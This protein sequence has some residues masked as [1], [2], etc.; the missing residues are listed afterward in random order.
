LDKSLAW[1]LAQELPRGAEGCFAR[2]VAPGIPRE[3]ARL[4]WCHGDAGVAAALLVAA[5]AIQEPALERV[6]LRIALRAAARSEA[7]A[8]VVD[9]GLCHGAAGVAH[10]FH[11]IYLATGEERI[12][13]AARAWFKRALAMRN[14]GRGFGGFL[15]YGP[16]GEG[17]LGRCGQPG[18]LSGSAGVT[19]ALLAATTGDDPV[20]D[21][22]LLLS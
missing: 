11:R 10:I 2:A 1:L 3:P 13:T 21:R 22:A 15:T 6:S 4:A 16:V 14:P 5:R 19:L 9:A 18:F 17:K 7:T 20:W 8:G 12:A